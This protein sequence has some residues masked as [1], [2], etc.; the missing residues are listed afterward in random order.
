MPPK[1]HISVT[2]KEAQLDFRHPGSLK[3]PVL[4]PYRNSFNPRNR[5]CIRMLG[6]AFCTSFNKSNLPAFHGFHRRHQPSKRIITGEAKFCIRL[7]CTHIPAVRQEDVQY[8][9]RITRIT[10][11]MHQKPYY[12]PHVHHINTQYKKS[13]PTIPLPQ[14][15]W[16]P[17]F[18]HL[19]LT[20]DCLITPSRW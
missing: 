4:Q 12:Y 19:P 5:G 14:Y 8:P 15:N 9:D 20:S 16:F 7:S 13:C 11:L 18:H 17:L 2:S 10:Y 6:R 1:L 3:V